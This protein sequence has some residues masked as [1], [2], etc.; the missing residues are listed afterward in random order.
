MTCQGWKRI[1]LRKKWRRQCRWY[2]EQLPDKNADRQAV[3]EQA[4]AEITV[5]GELAGRAR[6]ELDQLVA[7]SPICYGAERTNLWWRIVTTYLGSEAVVVAYLL[8]FPDQL[9]NAQWQSVQHYLV[10]AKK[11]DQAIVQ[12]AMAARFT[13]RQRASNPQEGGHHSFVH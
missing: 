6:R 12:S 9:T 5:D 3:L 1:D 8:R 10:C 7:Q 13:R 11:Y 2:L 4:L